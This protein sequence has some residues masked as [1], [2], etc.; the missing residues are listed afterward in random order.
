MARRLGQLLVELDEQARGCRSSLESFEG[1]RLTRR[2][3]LRLRCLQN[4][5]KRMP[6]RTSGS[7]QQLAMERVVGRRMW[8]FAEGIAG[9]AIAFV[10]A[11][12]L[13]VAD[14]GASVV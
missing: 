2:V 7:R 10:V 9:Q 14:F 8:G 3:S 1:E 11:Y 12:A 4:G 6:A 13:A 5:S